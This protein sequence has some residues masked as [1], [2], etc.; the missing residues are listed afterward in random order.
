MNNRRFAFVALCCIAVA[1]GCRQVADE[2]RSL[3]LATTTST[4]DSG[5]LDV[6]LPQFEEE[7]GITIKMIAVGSGQA[8][9]M[10]RRGDADVLLTHAP[11]AE[12]RFMEEGH[13]N[14]RYDVMYNDFVLVGPKANPAGV[15]K[16]EPITASLRRI[17]DAESLFVSRGDESGTH[18]K[19]LALWQ[20]SGITPKGD[21]YIEVGA[22]MAQTLRVASEKQAYTLSDRGTFL[23]QRDGLHLVILA[24]GDASLRNPYSVITI[25]AGKHP[26]VHEEEAR[27]FAEFLVSPQTQ[28]AIAE[29]GVDRFGQPL[30]FPLHATDD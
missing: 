23:A 7:T 6:L 20:E 26:G 3:T 18:M 12:K 25:D 2:H 19:E 8:L 10:G 17:A 22:G 11:E 13:G 24:E 15:V 29:F 30:F 9:E 21:W 4:R 5:L 27:R 16:D 28:R 14:L 1:A